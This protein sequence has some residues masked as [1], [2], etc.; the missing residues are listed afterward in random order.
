MDS[1]R[2][3]VRPAL[4]SRQNYP[5]VDLSSSARACLRCR[6]DEARGP[7]HRPDHHGTG[8]RPRVAARRLRPYDPALGRAREDRSRA[9]LPVPDPRRERA[10]RLRA[11]SRR[12]VRLRG[13]S[14]ASGQQAHLRGNRA[15]PRRVPSPS[16]VRGRRDTTFF[17]ARTGTAG[18]PGTAWSRRSDAVNTERPDDASDAA[19]VPE[20]GGGVA[21]RRRSPVV[22]AAVAAAVLFVA[23]GGA[24]LAATLSGGAG[25]SP[26][27]GGD[28]AP[29]ALALDGYGEGGTPGI[30]VG[31]PNPYGT[32]YR[33]AGKLPDGP[34]SAPV[35]W[36]K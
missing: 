14:R 15:L 20:G 29:P 10:A 25:G 11:P 28:G 27:R 2:Y 18:S 19:D 6:H 5:M 33:A 23:G 7:R 4:R 1:S 17:R 31:E 13:L 8:R 32:T 24:Y 16:P 9:G 21:A 35:Y 26:A 34:G 22:V 3:P 36:A 12:D 30:A